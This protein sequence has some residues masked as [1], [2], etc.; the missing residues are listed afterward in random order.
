MEFNKVLII[1]SEF[2]PQP[3]GMGNHAYNLAVQLSNRNY[4]VS[5]LTDYR[6]SAKVVE[7]DFDSRQNFIILR[8]PRFKILIYT[9]L[10]RLWAFHKLIESNKPD[11]LIAS[12]KFP[13]WMVAF[14]AKNKRSSED[15]ACS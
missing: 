2:P 3:G 1:C 5:V 9:Y 14:M 8:I 7:N 11:V 6:T 4:D 15:N 13:L 12:G 10:K